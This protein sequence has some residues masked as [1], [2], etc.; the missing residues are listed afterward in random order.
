MAHGAAPIGNRTNLL[1]AELMRRSF[2][3]DPL[4]C[5]D[6]GSRLRLLAIIEASAVVRPILTHLGLPTEVP[7]FEPS[8]APPLDYEGDDIDRNGHRQSDE[9]A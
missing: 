5:P 1:W 7:S 4:T 6:C 2:G 8:R 3:L 9:P